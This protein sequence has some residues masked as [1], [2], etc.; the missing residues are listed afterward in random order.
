MTLET[1]LGQAEG[2]KAEKEGETVET[3]SVAEATGE[4][5]SAILK[6]MENNYQWFP[7][8]EKNV[9]FAFDVA[10]QDP[11]CRRCEKKV[12]ARQ[13]V[14]NTVIDCNICN[15]TW[16]CACLDPPINTVKSAQQSFF[17]CGPE[18]VVEVEGFIAQ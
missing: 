18:C 2:G 14:A 6:K 10:D 4:K 12:Y 5:L 11:F 15:F 9:K 1:F 3:D 8:V 13:K 7:G 17:A 16:H